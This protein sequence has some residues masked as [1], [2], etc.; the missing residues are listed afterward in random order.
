MTPE[1]GATGK[2]RSACQWPGTSGG[3]PGKSFCHEAVH[4]MGMALRPSSPHTRKEKQGARP[5]REAQREE[6][7][8]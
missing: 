5:W 4:G 3:E 1:A 7:D 8:A 6:C 2:R